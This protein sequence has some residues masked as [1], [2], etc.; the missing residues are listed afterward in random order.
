M[1]LQGE[2]V[3]P[4]TGSFESRF[5]T[6]FASYVGYREWSLAMG[7]G[8][9]ACD[10]MLMSRFWLLGETCWQFAAP[11]PPCSLASTSS[12]GDSHWQTFSEAISAQRRGKVSESSAM[13]G[14]WN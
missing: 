14:I 3:P 9:G 11:S 7:S 12:Q 8:A 5:S 6:K 10:P 1:R 13:I 4:A 2:I